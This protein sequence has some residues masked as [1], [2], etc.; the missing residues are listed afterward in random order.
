M[1]RDD[2][3]SKA[4]KAAQAREMFIPYYERQEQKI[5]D[6]LAA[7]EMDGSQAVTDQ[8]LEMVRTLQN[9]RRTLRDMV[10]DEDIGKHQIKRL[11]AAESQQ[12][13]VKK[14]PRWS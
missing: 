2:A 1:A 3:I 12:R 4:T 13:R 11:E 6:K 8:I 9:A 14:D 7:I 10:V 5:L